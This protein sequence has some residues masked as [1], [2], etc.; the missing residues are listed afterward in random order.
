L[1]VPRSCDP[2]FRFFQTYPWFGLERMQTRAS[3]LCLSLAASSNLTSHT[4]RP[5][6]SSRPFTL[7]ERN[8]FVCWP[9]GTT[10]TVRKA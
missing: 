10:T 5:I 6:N 7:R 4:E 9:L 1:L 2:G 3:L 8:H